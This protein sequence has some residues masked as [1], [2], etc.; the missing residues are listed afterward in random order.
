[1]H[2]HHPGA[3]GYRRP[4]RAGHGIGN[5]VE[6]Q[7]EKHAVATAG[8]LVHHG[9]SGRREQLLADLVAADRSTQQVGQRNRLGGGVDIKGNENRVH[10]WAAVGGVGSKAPTRSLKRA[11]LWRVR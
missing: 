5:V 8:Q 11:T 3:G 4:H 7:V 2:V 9:R 10:A 1:M 6:F